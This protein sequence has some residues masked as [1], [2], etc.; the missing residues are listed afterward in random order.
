MGIVPVRCA[1]TLPLRGNA[2]WP[3]CNDTQAIWTK[4]LSDSILTRI[5]G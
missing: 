5:K 3:L 2:A 1:M 4:R